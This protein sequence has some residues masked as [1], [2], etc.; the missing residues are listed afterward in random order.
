MAYNL[1]MITKIIPFTDSDFELYIPW[2]EDLAREGLFVRKLYGIYGDFEQGEPAQL[3]YRIIPTSK[4]KAGEDE[5][6]FFEENGW[7]YVCKKDG[8][9]IFCKADDGSPDLFTDAVSFAERCRSWQFFML[10]EI[11]LYIVI[12][13]F[14]SRMFRQL[15]FAESGGWLDALHVLGPVSLVS[16]IL[17]LLLAFF[18]A[19]WRSVSSIFLVRRIQEGRLRMNRSYR[20]A[21]FRNKL[22]L[23]LYF[24]LFISAHLYTFRI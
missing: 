14:V 2:L 18:I 3:R 10:A 13:I 17:L 9:S 22:I 15:I 5:K 12:A 1:K 4:G 23:I 7:D 6:A 8:L 20:K 19:A 16:L 21:V 24:I 11:A